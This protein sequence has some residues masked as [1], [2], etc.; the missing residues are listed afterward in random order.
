MDIR[1]KDFD[2]HEHRNENMN[3]HS[4][5]CTSRAELF[6]ENAEAR[7]NDKECAA[8]E[9]QNIDEGYCLSTSEQSAAQEE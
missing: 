8:E 7:G 9:I 4:D 3:L 5:H 2:R 6:F 1:E